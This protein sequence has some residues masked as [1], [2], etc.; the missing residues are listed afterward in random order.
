MRHPFCVFRSFQPTPRTCK[1]SLWLYSYWSWST[2]AFFYLVNIV[3]PDLEIFNSLEYHMLNVGRGRML[4]ELVV[5]YYCTVSNKV[6]AMFSHFRMVIK[7]LSNQ[8][9]YGHEIMIPCKRNHL[10][11]L[12]LL[13][14]FL[15]HMENQTFHGPVV[16]CEASECFVQSSLLP[17][18]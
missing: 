14:H 9:C 13:L 11:Y 10:L 12:L 1:C 8:I 3:V 16:T 17:S 4:R 15:G 5:S 6:V 2:M 18:I 7:Y